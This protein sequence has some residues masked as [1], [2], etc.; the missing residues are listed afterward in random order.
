MM[1][2]LANFGTYFFSQTELLA[3]SQGNLVADPPAEFIRCP[4]RR[5]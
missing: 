2:R 1:I 4:R 5:C 3:L